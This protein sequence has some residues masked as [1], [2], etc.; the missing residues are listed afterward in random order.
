MA[1][2]F[3]EK[4]HLD[5]RKKYWG[6]S[7]DENLEME[8]ILKGKYV[9]IRPAVGYPSMKDQKEIEK[10]FNILKSENKTNVEITESY[11]IDPA[12]SV[13]GLYF[14]NKNA[15]YFDVYKIDENQLE[16]YSKRNGSSIAEL[17]GRL[18][19]ISK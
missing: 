2:A 12:S 17:K 6:Y 5:I 14:A 15:K 4:L 10:I 8:D 11:M 1:E 9:G 3:A 13:C 7:E 16:D 18:P 19:Y